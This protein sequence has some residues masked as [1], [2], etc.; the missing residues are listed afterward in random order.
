MDKALSI[1]IPVHNRADD[2]A[3]NLVALAPQC[4]DRS[5][6]IIV[7]DSASDPAQAAAI[8]ALRDVAPIR[9]LRLDEP[10]VSLARNSGVAKARGN[11]LGFL[12]DDVVTAPDWV[13]TALARIGP[14]QDRLGVVAGRVRPRWP[15]S[16]PRGGFVPSQLDPRAVGLLSII[17]AADS[18]DSTDAPRGISANLLLR[19]SALAQVGG[20]PEGMGR[21]GTSLASGEDPFV[22]DAIVQRGYTSWYDGN[23]CVEHKIHASQLARAWLARRA[24]HEGMV[25]LRRH[26][27]R[28][29]RLTLTARCAA[30]IPVLAMLRVCA[31]SSSAAVVRLHHN[32][33]VLYGAMVRDDMNHPARSV[34]NPRSGLRG[35]RAS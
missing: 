32:L 24:W 14:G 31:P 5:I 1:I 7:V 18:H 25:S 26:H 17:D 29:A 16:P 10:G 11:W 12:D 34:L 27:S 9:L 28:H 30:S 33:G 15:Q 22:I 35:I 4:R 3:E 20:F 21:T 8:R 19:K 6:E 2:L 23:L 13:A